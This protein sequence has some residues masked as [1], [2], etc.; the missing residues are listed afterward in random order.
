MVRPTNITATALIRKYLVAESPN[1]GHTYQED[2]KVKKMTHKLFPSFHRNHCHTPRPKGWETQS[3]FTSALGVPMLFSRISQVFLSSEFNSVVSHRTNT[4]S[5]HY[6]LSTALMKNRVRK[7]PE[8]RNYAQRDD[9]SVRKREKRQ[10]FLSTGEKQM[11]TTVLGKCWHC[12]VKPKC[13]WF[14]WY[15]DR[16]ASFVY[17]R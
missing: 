10:D 16:I 8:S 15:Q 6:L 7:N 3:A 5:Q 14:P 11:D 4:T 13:V 9:S 17:T 12:L 2:P 1:W